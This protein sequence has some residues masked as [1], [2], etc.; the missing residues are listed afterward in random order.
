MDRSASAT[1]RWEEEGEYFASF[2]DVLRV[3][4]RRLWAVALAAVFVTG[5]VTGYGLWR[6]PVYEAS[7]RLLVSQQQVGDAEASGGLSG[8]VQGLEQFTKTVAEAVGGRRVAEGAI[9][10]A[11]L[12]VT[13]EM[14]SSNLDVEQV[15]GTQFIAVAY[16]D[17]DPARAMETAN[18]VAQVTSEEIS[19]I[20]PSTAVT[21]IVWEPASQPQAPA[22]PDLVRDGLLALLLGTLLGVGLAFLLERLDNSW[23]SPEEAELI[24]GVPTLAVIPKFK[25]PKVKA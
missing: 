7:A 8:E 1:P 15:E 25:S 10:E 17:P 19:A 9:R 21:A 14:L 12:P 3:V 13:P 22:S 18:A 20:S 5:A 16:G 6:T 11:G 2:D 24:S 23:R 4:W